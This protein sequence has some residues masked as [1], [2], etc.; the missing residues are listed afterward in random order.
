MTEARRIVLSPDVMTTSLGDGQ[1]LMKPN[2]VRVTL[3]PPSD[4]E[5][6]FLGN[7]YIYD[8]EDDDI[9]ELI[10][11]GFL[12]D[13]NGVDFL[14][15]HKQQAVRLPENLTFGFEV[16]NGKCGIHNSEGILSLIELVS[17]TFKP[18]TAFLCV[19]DD[20][21]LDV[22]LKIM[23]RLSS[24][25][26]FPII[27][28]ILRGN[29]FNGSKLSNRHLKVLDDAVLEI[30]SSATIDAALLARLCNSFE[31]IFEESED[32][33]LISR[34]QYLSSQNFNIWNNSFSINSSGYITLL[35]GEF[36]D[37]NCDI[38]KI[39][40]KLK[41][42]KNSPSLSKNRSN[43]DICK[44][45]ALRDFCIYPIG[46]KLAAKEPLR[47]DRFCIE[48]NNRNIDISESEVLEGERIK[49]T[50]ATSDELKIHTLEIL[51]SSIMTKLDFHSVPKFIY[52]WDPSAGPK[53]N[54]AQIRFGKTLSNE[55]IISSHP[56]HTHEICHIV[57]N[58]INPNQ[59]N[60][61]LREASASMFGLT[62]EDEN[63]I[64]PQGLENE[65]EHLHK[66][67]YEFINENSVY[68]NIT[69]LFKFSSGVKLPYK[70]YYLGGSFLNFLYQEF[71]ASKIK[72]IYLYPEPFVS[73]TEVLK[74]SHES[75]ETSWFEFLLNYNKSFR[76][77]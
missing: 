64:D 21:S 59:E 3:N 67:S 14:Y 68:R 18:V 75:L 44:N 55:A 16:K 27:K 60:H 39:K 53:T 32:T 15:A 26:V 76:N 7:P 51:L 58:N 36:Y 71:G 8:C 54:L 52:H 5:A 70:L 2:G 20:E 19:Y 65:V 69:S 4:K 63:A 73:I 33:L 31:R 30:G 74:I 40:D 50:K 11:L 48:S 49:V 42:I 6:L 46:R 56:Y 61:F 38:G 29:H 72:E 24:M 12:S 34:Q 13:Y 9:E 25:A 41:K 28:M 45:C 62:Y 47:C 43:I 66:K 37:F 10:R 22:G 35:D 1:S 23:D 17:E 57:F 77:V